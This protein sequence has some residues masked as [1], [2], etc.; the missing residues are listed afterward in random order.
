MVA[1]SVLV[2]KVAKTVTFANTWTT[3]LMTFNKAIINYLVN[4]NLTSLQYV[5]IEV[6]ATWLSQSH[7]HHACQHIWSYVLSFGATRHC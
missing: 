1:V 7:Y 4:V 6:M 5:V 2:A 3:H